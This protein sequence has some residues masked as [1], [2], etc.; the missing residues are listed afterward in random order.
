M[1]KLLC[2]YVTDPKVY[3]DDRL[4][5]VGESV[6]IQCH[7]L[8]LESVLWQ[9]KRGLAPNVHDVYDIDKRVVSSYEN[10]ATVNESTYDLTIYH[11]DVRDSG[12]YW[13]IE[14]GGFGTKHVT[15]LYVTGIS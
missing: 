14:D 15:Q 13:C 11:I 10:R 5:A 7:V 12:E 2:V 1:N 8:S 3:Y 4:V 9:F 6:T